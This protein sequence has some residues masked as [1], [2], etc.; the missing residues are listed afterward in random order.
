[1][2]VYLYVYLYV[3]V[4]IGVLDVLEFETR[5]SLGELQQ[6]DLIKLGRVV[7]SLMTRTVITSKNAEEAL[8]MMKQHYSSDLQ[9]VVAAL[10]SGKLTIFQISFFFK[11]FKHL[12][13]ISTNNTL[14]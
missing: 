3:Y 7:L 6:D 10:L 1:M 8:G 12:K 2:C 9:R 14:C 5:K 13:N 11:G 4:C